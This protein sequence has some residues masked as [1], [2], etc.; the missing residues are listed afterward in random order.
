MNDLSIA[1]YV[2]QSKE[3][4]ALIKHIGIHTSERLHKCDI[5]F[6]RFKDESGL[7]SRIQIDVGERLYE[8]KTHFKEFRFVSNVHY[9]TY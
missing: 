6:K 3:N 4:L 8:C 2:Q 9:R 5:C 1:K 7:K